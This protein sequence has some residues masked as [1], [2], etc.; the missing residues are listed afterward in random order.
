M[1]AVNYCH[2]TSL[3]FY[4]NMLSLLQS[5]ITQQARQD[6]LANLPERTS[7]VLTDLLIDSGNY[8]GE[9][10]CQAHSCI[11]QSFPRIKIISFTIKPV[12]LLMGPYFPFLCS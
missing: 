6:K 11:G 5:L 8:V 2:Q 10:L 12:F 3:E 4:S 1:E 9:A 7:P